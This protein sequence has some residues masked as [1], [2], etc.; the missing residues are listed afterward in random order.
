MS[1][2]RTRVRTRA[3]SPTTPPAATG[4]GPRRRGA[5]QWGRGPPRA[6]FDP[7]LPGI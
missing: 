2:R 1:Q 4:S 3:V 7:A 5:H 6:G